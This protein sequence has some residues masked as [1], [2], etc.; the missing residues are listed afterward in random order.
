MNKQELIELVASKGLTKTKI[1]AE[2]IVEGI[3]SEI[4]STVAAGQKVS[5]GGFGIFEKQNRKACTGRN[6]NTGEDVQ[7]PAM[8]VAKF[9]PAKAF[10]DAVK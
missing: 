1:D 10:K 2:C 5:I 7:I 3:F 6:P 8:G 4:K 9:R